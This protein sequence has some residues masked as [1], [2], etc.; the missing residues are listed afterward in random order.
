MARLK[1]SQLRKLNRVIL[2]LYEETEEPQPIETI[3]N[4]VET[5]LP[6]PW[7]CVDEVN[8]SS[9]KLSHLAGRRIEAVPQL[10]EKLKAYCHENPVVS[11]AM[12]GN[13]APALRIS[14]FTTFRQFKK[15]NYFNEMVGYFS[16]WRDQAA[17]AIRLPGKSLGFALSRDKLFSDEELLILELLQPHLERVLHRSTQFLQLPTEQPLTPREREVLHWVVEGKRDGEISIIL[18][19][20][21]RTVEHHVRICLRKL[22]VETRAAAC[23][24]VWRAKAQLNRPTPV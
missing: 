20:S 15:T 9:G 1:I 16:G 24:T 21:V 6:I 8:L 4:L 12:Q 7:I 13:F 2:S 14:D 17:I 19:I 3:I 11:Y 5:L 23:A 22:G 10:D 18:S